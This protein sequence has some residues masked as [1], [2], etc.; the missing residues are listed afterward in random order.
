MQLVNGTMRR[1]RQASFSHVEASVDQ[2][3]GP[4]AK[5]HGGDDQGNVAPRICQPNETDGGP[6]HADGL[7]DPSGV[8][9]R[10]PSR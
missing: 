10:H 8:D 7:K 2:G 9:F 6:K 1:R 3:V 5:A 4:D